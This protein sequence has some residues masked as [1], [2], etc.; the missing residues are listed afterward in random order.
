[1]AGP[2]QRL[3]DRIEAVVD[4]PTS[5][6]VAV[7]VIEVS[8][9]PSA[10]CADLAKL[11]ETDPSL[12]SRFLSLTNSAWFG[13]HQ[14]VTRVGQAVN[15]LGA[16]N[17]RALSVSHSLSGL[18]HG[19]KLDAGDA[20]AYWQ[21]ALLKAAAGELLRQEYSGS[22]TEETF[23]LGLLQDIGVSLLASDGVPE[24][25]ELLRSEDGE[26]AECLEFERSTFGLDHAEC[27]ALLAERIGLPEP[28]PEAIRTHHEQTQSVDASDGPH[29]PAGLIISLLPHDLRT[30]SKRDF[31]RL[32]DVIA[33]HFAARWNDAHQFTEELQVRFAALTDLVSGGS[34]KVPTLAELTARATLILSQSAKDVVAEQQ[35]LA[36]ENRNLTRHMLATE[37]KHRDAEERATHDPLTGLLNRDGFAR[38]SKVL[39]REARVRKRPIAL[40][41]IDLDYF[42]AIN[43]VHGHACGDEVL[44]VVA[45]RMFS[46]VRGRELI[47]RWGGDEILILSEGMCK[48]D[49]HRATQRLIGTVEGN[50]ITWRGI[51]LDVTLSV[52]FEWV[53]QV[54]EGFDIDHLI[55][56]VDARMYENKRSSRPHS[57][58]TV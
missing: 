54:G 38:E 44:Q 27:G 47:C 3:R 16:S 23:T 56:R 14:K 11:I 32:D 12:S 5:F 1:M 48:D 39:L 53:Q 20:K 2:A 21:A 51:R 42:K 7:R 4:L 49:S 30:W 22:Q 41:L 45:R 10:G 52:G 13:L 37:T 26:L 40:A 6:A 19:W 15:L 29:D 18:Y 33:D 50:P 28:F 55:E 46:S 25:Q 34:S 9:D 31:G 35:S 24:Y 17:V 43:D 36:C 57:T 8:R 58:R